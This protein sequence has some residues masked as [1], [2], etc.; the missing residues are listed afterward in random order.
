M[1]SIFRAA[2]R[3]RLVWFEWCLSFTSRQCPFM[4]AG[5]GI[6]TVC[7]TAHRYQ[8]TLRANTENV[9]ERMRSVALIDAVKADCK[10]ETK[11]DIV[12]SE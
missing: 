2:Q 11:Y 5:T 1:G 10:S 7:V 3:H 12:Q 6:G 9:S 8:G 4:A